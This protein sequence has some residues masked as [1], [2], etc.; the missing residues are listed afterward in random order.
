MKSKQ[1]THNLDFSTN[2]C[3]YNFKLIS[4]ILLFII[5]LCIISL[6]I[7]KIS[8]TLSCNHIIV[9]LFLMLFRS[10]FSLIYVLFKTCKNNNY[11]HTNNEGFCFLLMIC[12]NLYNVRLLVNTT[13]NNYIWKTIPISYYFLV[14]YFIIEL[15]M[16]FP[17][18]IYHLFLPL[19]RTKISK[20]EVK[21]LI[22]EKINTYY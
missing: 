2:S 7:T 19:M 3:I 20:E 10:V 16:G 8:N 22:T 6:G 4:S 11:Y 14:S 13:C 17:I 1:Y 9:S 5:S 18:L 15:F 12:I 21:H